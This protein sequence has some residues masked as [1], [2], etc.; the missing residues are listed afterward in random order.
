[1]IYTILRMGKYFQKC[2]ASNTPKIGFLKLWLGE[3]KLGQ[4]RYVTSYPEHVAM[5]H[6]KQYSYV[7]SEK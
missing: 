6:I 4:I 5:P 2:L 7:Q 1:M 3:K